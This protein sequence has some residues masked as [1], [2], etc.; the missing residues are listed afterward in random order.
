[1]ATLEVRT[2]QAELPYGIQVAGSEWPDCPVRLT[3]DS[4]VAPAR[5]HALLGDSMR[6]RVQPIAGEFE[7]VLDLPGLKPGKHTIEA[8]STARE[9][10][11]ANA[12]F[13]LLD[14]PELEEDGRPTLRPLRRII[15]FNLRRF[16]D[17]VPRPGARLLALAARDALRLRQADDPSPPVDPGCN[18]YPIG[19]SVV[20]AGQVFSTTPTTFVTAPIS[21]RVTAIAIDPNDVQTIYAATAQGGLWKSAN[22]GRDWEPKSDYTPSL[23][24]GSV[25]VDPSVTDAAGRSTRIIIGTGEP[26][27]SDSYYGA[28]I[29]LSTD[30]GETWAARGTTTFV[31]AA[32]SSIGIDPDDNQHLIAASDI[33]VHESTDEGVNW[34]LLDA[35]ASF[36]LVVDW[37]NSG[38]AE[39]YVGRTGVGVRR[40]VGT[41]AWTTLGGGLPAATGRVALAMAPSAPD[42]IYAAVPSGGTV[43]FYRTTNGG[44]SWTATGGT[45]A[46]AQLTYN[47]TLAVHPTDPNTLLF[48]E[49][50]LWRSTN[51]GASWTRVSTGSPGIHA[52]QHALAFDPTDGTRVFAGNDGG[53]WLSTNGGVA[54]THRN[55]DLATLQYFGAANHGQREAIML[56]GT[57]DNGAQRYVG[58]PAWEHSALGDGAFCAIDSTSDPHR[59]FETRWYSF[60][61]FRSDNS[62][63]AGSWVAKQSG[64]TTNSNW[65][66]PPFAMDPNDS[67]VIY[68]AYDRLYR[69]SDRGETWTALTGVLAAGVNISA[70][71]IAPSNS[72]IVYVGL[73]NGRVFSVTGSGTSWTATDISAAPIPAGQ[74]SDIAVHP[75]D[76]ST[77][78]VTTSDLI[79]SE[80]SESF[81]ADHVY[82]TTNGGTSWASVS[83]GLSQANPVNTIVIDPSAPQTLFIGCDVGIFRSDNGGTS[84]AAWDQG[85]PNCS[86]QDLQLFAPGRLLRAATHGRSVWER[87]IDAAT[88]PSVSLYVRDNLLD[89]GGVTPSPS[90]VVHPF[91]STDWVYWWQSADIKVD[92]PDPATNAYAFPGLDIDYL[93]FE[94]HLHENPR[95]DTFVRVYAQVHARGTQR[96]TSVRVRAFWA[97]ASLALPP[98]PSDF[99]MVFPNADPM[100]TTNWHPVGPA[101]TITSIAPARPKV[102]GWSWHVPATAPTHTCMLVVA[103][104]AEDPISVSGTDVGAAVNGSNH[105]TLKNLHVDAVVPGA[106]GADTP[107]GPYMVELAIPRAQV[108]IDIRFNTRG[109]PPGALMHIALPKFKATGGLRKALRGI[110]AAGAA[111]EPL[112]ALEQHG[113]RDPVE[114]DWDR[115]FTLE[116]GDPEKLGR[117]LPGIYGVL[118]AT[119]RF[120]AALTVALP[121]V[122]FERPLTFHLEQWVG[123]RL[124]GGSSYELR[125]S[126]RRES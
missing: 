95:R 96:A 114:F 87:P 100:D 5:M 23:A 58:H 118:P 14:I 28:G 51:A 97:D 41:G 83:T 86:V 116:A 47:L 45:V 8:V 35:G 88:C 2:P 115:V 12:S 120:A 126:K 27:N 55:K 36:D 73:R 29:L 112:R 67:T 101:K 20:R 43:T 53:V 39:V 79:F 18:W 110:K 37:A 61:C 10:E 44:T 33:G 46:G 109:L 7:V 119:K 21:G 111:P 92:S 98:L 59:W 66:Y 63:A 31:R 4:E 94:D 124:A 106:T 48:G 40:R 34:T 85:L 54:W 71:A 22:G 49:V 104:C 89:T 74:I 91:V 78:Y 65:F 3:V 121:D 68:T 77:I 113:C 15:D 24:C 117:E 50:H 57:Q 6:T 17:G 13:E 90:G 60:P 102:V 1:M 125:P 108:P 122:E 38:G 103:T 64:I 82:R 76:P 75:T 72:G 105:V 56:G 70:I 19:P 52:D 99:W 69:S 107:A 30:G 26:N 11:R 32:F 42:T 62:G 9:G 16:P 93:Q 80:G 84:W 81:A 25:T 123:K